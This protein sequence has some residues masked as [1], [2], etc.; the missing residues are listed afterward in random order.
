MKDTRLT[1]VPF[2]AEGRKTVLLNQNGFT[3]IMALMLIMIMGIMLGM[4]GQSWKTIMQREREEELLFRGNQVVEIFNQKVACKTLRADQV[5]LWPK[6]SASGNVLD[7]LVIGVEEKCFDGSTKKLRLRKTAVIDPI[8]AD[9]WKL[10]TPVGANNLFA[11]VAST[12]S[13]EPLKKRDFADDLPDF[14]DKKMYSEW[15]FSWE[16]MKKRL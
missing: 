10:L 14:N 12:S 5:T 1:I 16:L 6:D 13:E 8:T 9:K 15:E 7:A 4:T 2:V 11:G 3:Y